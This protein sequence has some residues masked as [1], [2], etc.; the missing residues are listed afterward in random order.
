MGPWDIPSIKTWDKNTHGD[1]WGP[2]RVFYRISQLT[3]ESR[4]REA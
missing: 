2:E 4:Q 1:A 3:I